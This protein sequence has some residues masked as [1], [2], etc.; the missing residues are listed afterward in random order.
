MYRFDGGSGSLLFLRSTL[1]LRRLSG[2]LFEYPCL[3]YQDLALGAPPG[4]RKFAERCSGRDSLCGIPFSGI[5]D[6]TAFQADI[7]IRVR[8]RRGVRHTISLLGSNFSLI[9]VEKETS[10]Y[11]RD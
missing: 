6:V 2:E 5:I 9:K 8:I 7:T 1:L 3:Q 10:D 11:P 4:S